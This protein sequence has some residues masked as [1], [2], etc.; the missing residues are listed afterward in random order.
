MGP[1]GLES[2]DI[3]GEGE[4]EEEDEMEDD[5]EVDP[6]APA[7]LAAP[8]IGS[9]SLAVQPKAKAGK[10]KGRGKKRKQGGEDDDDDELL[11]TE[12]ASNAPTWLAKDQRLSKV[13]EKVGKMY[14]CFASMNPVENLMKRKPVGHQIWG[15][16]LGKNKQ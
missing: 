16:R 2:Q 5:M 6:T 15:V 14:K 11:Q 8:S 7:P 13:V 4:G 1:E 12:V 10:G 3:A 9:G